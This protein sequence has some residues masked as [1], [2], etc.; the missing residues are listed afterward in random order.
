MTRNRKKSR[1]RDDRFRQQRDTASQTPNAVKAVQNSRR[2]LAAQALTASPWWPRLR[3]LPWLL[4]VALFLIVVF[5]GAWLCDDAFI[6]FRTADNFVH[7]YGLTWNVHERVQCLHASLVAIAVFGGL[8]CDPGA[9][10]HGHFP[11]PGGVGGSRAVFA[12]KIAAS[13]AG[14]ALGVLALTFSLAFVDYSTSGLE[15]PLTH[16]L[17]A[18]FL[19]LYLTRE[20]TIGGEPIAKLD[21]TPLLLS[22]LA[23]LAAVNRMDSTLL[24]VPSLAYLLFER[25]IVAMFLVDGFGL[26]SA[27]LGSAF[28]CS[29]MAFR[30]PT[31]P[32]RNSTTGFPPGRWPHED[33][34]FSGTR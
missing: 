12:W 31:R 26:A 33:V 21:R 6:S 24:F 27:F 7:G 34:T 18:L 16:L 5:R 10:L 9:I 11:V 28:R 23:A 3:H 29:T 32:M 20:A 25:Q 4:A 30:F 19:W 17:L 2:A 1:L 14:A 13:R 8:L 15:N 22:L